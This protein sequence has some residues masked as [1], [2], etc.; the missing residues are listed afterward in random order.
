MKNRK[1]GVF[2]LRGYREKTD[3]DEYGDVRTYMSAYYYEGRRGKRYLFVISDWRYYEE[4]HLFHRKST[5]RKVAK[6]IFI[7]TG[8]KLEAVKITE[9]EMDQFRKKPV[10]GK[11]RV[12][13]LRRLK[14]KEADAL[15]EQGKLHFRDSTNIT[16]AKIYFEYYMGN[17]PFA[18]ANCYEV[19]KRN[20]KR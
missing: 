1:K 3:T 18:P 13:G 12:R 15:W 2:V 10:I 4:S 8:R 11:R 6:K 16:S 20:N 7:E 9:G 5:A 17:D 14:P 19:Q